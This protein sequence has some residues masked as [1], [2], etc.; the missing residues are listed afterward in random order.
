L[1]AS[2]AKL[3]LIGGAA[4]LVW[5]FPV[6]Q[7]IGPHRARQILQ[8][9]TILGVACSLALLGAELSVR[10]LYRNITTTSDNTSYFARR[11]REHNPPVTNEHGFRERAYRKLPA[12]GVHRICV[13]GDSFT[14]GQGI[15]ESHRLTD[16]LEARLNA[17]QDGRP[18]E[19][20]NFGLPGASTVE[21]LR[22][23]QEV[24][25]DAAPDYI[26]LQWLSNDVEG[27]VQSGRPRPI[28][29]IPSSTV[30][31][32]LHRQSALYYLTHHAWVTLQEGI[33]LKKTYADYMV[34]RFGDPGSEGARA[35]DRVLEEFLLRCRDEGVAVGMILYP[36]P[37]DRDPG[38][39]DR[40][41]FLLD[42]VVGPCDRLGVP[43]VDLRRAFRGVHP[44]R[45]LWVNPLDSHPGPLANKLAADAVLRVFG[46]EWSGGRV[47]QAPP[48]SRNES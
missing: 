44:A 6:R 14:Y 17:G 37:A 45:K 43:Y 13:I 34:D 10:Y 1:A 31:S 29:L 3:L 28:P 7:R 8:N 21:H 2:V 48:R 38:K 18:Y 4:I 11:W 39:E 16:I 19:V 46:N 30:S 40:L 27:G 20:L 33:R 41:D 47:S 25:L 36:R 9:L 22:T 5:V 35:A 15:E 23:L 12:E 42:R 24:V 26:L 32:I